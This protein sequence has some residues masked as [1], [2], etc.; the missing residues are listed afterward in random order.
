[1]PRLRLNEPINSEF[2]SRGS[3]L[4]RA[5]EFSRRAVF[6]LGECLSRNFGVHATYDFAYFPVRVV[7][8][9]PN[10]LAS[11]I[12]AD[13]ARKDTKLKYSLLKCVRAPVSPSSPLPLE[14]C[15]HRRFR[16]AFFKHEVG[17]D[18]ISKCP[19]SRLVS[20]RPQ[21]LIP[22]ARWPNPF[23]DRKFNS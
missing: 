5:R 6:R 18:Y 4:A 16:T 23:A 19:L 3:T 11:R 12:S 1:M 7:F 22:T 17:G 8:N 9:L 2:K 13:Q 14:I 20:R 10:R 21:P 15:A